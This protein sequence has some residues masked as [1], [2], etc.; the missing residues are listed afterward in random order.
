MGTP[1]PAPAAAALGRSPA[2]AALPRA[3]WKSNLADDALTGNEGGDADLTRAMVVD[4]EELL[5]EEEAGELELTRWEEALETMKLLAAGGVAGAVSKSCTAPLSRLTILYQVRGLQ[6]AQPGGAAALPPG[7]AR[8]GVA[9]ALR[10][11]VAREGVAALWKGNGVTIVHRLPYSAANFW[12]YEVVNEAWK[13]RLPARGPLAPGDVARRLA[14]GGVAGSAACALAYP[15][16]LVRTRLAAQAGARYYDGIAHA[17]ASIAREEGARGL[18]RGLG[19]TLAQV[20]PSLAINYAAY[21]TARSAWL[22]AAD[23]A[24][25]TVPMSLACGSAAGLVS[26]TATFPLDLVRR[27]LQLQGQGGAPPV[28]PSYA[29]AF[30]TIAATEGLRGLYSG[31]LPEYYKVV[32]GVAIAFATY[33]VLKRSMGVRTNALE[34]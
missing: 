21:E 14:A 33:E 10:H 2:A 25:P 27:R 29:A 20:A 6:A 28:Y 1:A 4:E 9:A 31:I 7:G 22:A 17:L 26:S 15:L 16:D 3:P 12:T 11:I 23:V 13:R 24:A 34:R 5:E 19:A 30:R 18:Y 8:A 32:P